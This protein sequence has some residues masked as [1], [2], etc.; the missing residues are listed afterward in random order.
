MTTTAS[1][2]DAL[3]KRLDNVPKPIRTLHLCEDA[4]VRDRYLEAKQTHEQAAAYLKQFPKDSDPEALALV[5][6]QAKD[7]ATELAAAKKAYDQATIT[8]R[9]TAL[10]RGEL[11]KLQNAHPATEQ[12]EADGQDYAF[13]TFAPALIAAASLDGMPADYA[14]KALDAWAPSDARALWQA[15]WSIQ[16]T[17]RTDLGKG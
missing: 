4:D 6:K 5:Q 7:A 12:N 2:W 11:E 8:L 16:H 17:Q 15:A 3:A 9:F 13:D 1:G 10:E 14:A